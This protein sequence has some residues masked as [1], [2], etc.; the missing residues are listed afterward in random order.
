MQVHA[1]GTNEHAN[2]NTN[3][4]TNETTNQQ[5]NKHD[6]LQYLLAEV[7]IIICHCS[8]QVLTFDMQKKVEILL[9][10]AIAPDGNSNISSTG[11][12][13]NDSLPL[14]AAADDGRIGC[15]SDVH[16]SVDRTR[17]KLFHGVQCRRLVLL[18]GEVDQRDVDRLTV[19]HSE[20]PRTRTGSSPRLQC[21]DICQVHAG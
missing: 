17:G 13:V 14:G 20:E 4:R 12:C 15:S 16:L 19:R 5:T 18:N 10:G 7:I 21:D 11:V 8:N 3:E 6:G 1:L 2:E 9:T